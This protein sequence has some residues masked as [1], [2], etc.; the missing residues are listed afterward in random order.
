MQPIVT[1]TFLPIP[2]PGLQKPTAA[3]RKAELEKAVD[4][5]A[6]VLFSQMFRE[7]REAGEAQDGDAVFGGG[8]TGVLM[9][10]MDEQLGKS[11]VASGGST[12]RDAML[13]QLT[14][15]EGSPTA[16]GGAP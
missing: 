3:A 15:R 11:Y 5:F 10:L 13:R 14:S 16:A 9:H 2:Q 4:D 8:D 6:T 7:M 12:L 1:P